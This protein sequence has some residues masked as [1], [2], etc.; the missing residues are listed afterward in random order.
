MRRRDFLSSLARRCAACGAAVSM[1][2]CGT[3]F[4]SERNF[5]PHSNQ[6]DWKIVALDGLGLLLFFIPGVVAFVVDFYTGAIY[7]PCEY[8][9][10]PAGPYYLYPAP[11]AAP[12]VAAPPPGAVYAPMA[13]APSPLT[14]AVEQGPAPRLVTLKRVMLAEEDRDPRGIERVVSRHIGKP[15]SLD[16]E[17]ARLSRLENLG[18]YG[19]HLKRHRSDRTFGVAV[20]TFFERLLGV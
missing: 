4:H 2:G 20:R 14:Y 8:C 15:V 10:P 16:D 7:L 6:L 19:E 18:E 1:S 11:A 13:G 12:P 5:Q 9:Q 17:Q 3:I